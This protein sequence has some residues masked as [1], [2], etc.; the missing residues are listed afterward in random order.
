VAAKGRVE[1]LRRTALDRGVFGSSRLW[2]GIAVAIYGVRL[3]RWMARRDTETV[4]IEGLQAGEALLIRAIPAD[5]ARRASK[6][7]RASRRRGGR[8][9][10]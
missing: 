6:A 3:L 2:A 9:P 7:R 5:E 8:S 4:A 10:Q 1:L